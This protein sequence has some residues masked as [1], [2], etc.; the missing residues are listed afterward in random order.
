MAHGRKKAPAGYRWK[1]VTKLNALGRGYTT[2]VLVPLDSMESKFK[3]AEQESYK[4][5]APYP[6][7]AV[8]PDVDRTP[9]RSKPT[10]RASAAI[11]PSIDKA[12]TNLLGQALDPIKNIPIKAEGNP[13]MTIN[14][15]FLKTCP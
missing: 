1:T 6:G 7:Q 14:I 13:A 8:D 11:K 3:E 10:T 15:A 5:F 4:A 9:V 12:P 2:H